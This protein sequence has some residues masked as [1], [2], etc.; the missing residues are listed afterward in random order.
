M[1]LHESAPS[2]TTDESVGYRVVE[3]IA[4]ATGTDP[5]AL[6]PPLHAVVDWD[7]LETLYDQRS[8]RER[9]APEVSFEYADL[10][11]RIDEGGRVSVGK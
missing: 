6:D 2:G 10:T 9:T 8:C 7:A 1:S 11:V 4:E 5:V 3:A